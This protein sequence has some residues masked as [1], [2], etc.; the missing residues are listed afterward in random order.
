MPNFCWIRIKPENVDKFSEEAE[1]E[2]DLAPFYEVIEQKQTH[3][4]GEREVGELEYSLS[5][6]DVGHFLGVRYEFTPALVA[7]DTEGAQKVH[8]K[9]VTLLKHGVVLPGP[10]RLTD[11][12][13]TGSMQVCFCR[14]FPNKWCP[15]FTGPTFSIM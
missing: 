1:D 3:A 15:S 13:V 2:T 8:H 7:E 4:E 5:R 10:P 6:E 14:P 9:Y 12:S 11:F